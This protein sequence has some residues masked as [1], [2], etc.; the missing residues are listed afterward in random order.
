MKESFLNHVVI[1]NFLLLSKARWISSL[2]FRGPNLYQ[3]VEYIKR[4]EYDLI[5]RVVNS[6]WKL[7]QSGLRSIYG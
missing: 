5:V 2:D 7:V 6:S 4:D 3:S 1:S